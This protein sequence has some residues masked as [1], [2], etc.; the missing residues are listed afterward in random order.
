[1]SGLS[2]FTLLIYEVVMIKHYS[3][4]EYYNFMNL[5]NLVILPVH[6]TNLSLYVVKGGITEDTSIASTAWVS[7]AII[8]IVEIFLMVIR[9]MNHIQVYEQMGQLVQLISKVFSDI[10]SFT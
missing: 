1:M 4:K 7:L 9:L 3:F 5:V 8:R 10:K 6:L 2:L